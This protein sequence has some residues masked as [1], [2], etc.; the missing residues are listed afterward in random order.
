MRLIT[1]VMLLLCWSSTGIQAAD[2]ELER[3]KTLFRETEQK[4]RALVDAA[5]DR[6]I[7]DASRDGDLDLTTALKSEQAR[8]KNSTE[9]PESAPMKSFGQKYGKAI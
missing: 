3:A 8:F 6:K 5:F 7:K 4:Q 1:C 2:D 9:L